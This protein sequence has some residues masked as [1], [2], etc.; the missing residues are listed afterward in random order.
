MI[1]TFLTSIALAA[2]LLISMPAVRA[3]ARQAI[4]SPD[5]ATLKLK[6]TGGR[7]RSL[8]DHRGKIVVLNFWATWCKPCRDEI[9]ILVSLDSR[10]RERG[11]D[12]ICASADDS[13]TQKNVAGFARRLKIGFPVWVGATMDDIK[14]LGLGNSIP[15]TV[16]I[17]RNGAVVGRILG[18]VGNAD[19][20]NRIEW[21]LGDR[22]T[23]APAAVVNTM[24]QI[25][26]DQQ[27]DS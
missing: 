5:E 25:K 20:Q 2:L 4:V 18:P 8:I 17:D 13:S 26:H 27:Q 10:Y 21:L 9:P 12:F 16:I 3:R 24:D 6:D 19:L 22:Q 23:P 15:A 1:R 14:R 7:P 11:V